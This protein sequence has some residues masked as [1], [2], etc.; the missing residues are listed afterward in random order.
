[1]GFRF[2]AERAAHELGIRGYV[3]NLSS[4]SVEVYAIGDENTLEAFQRL[5]AQGPRSAR[6]NGIQESEEPVRK[7]YDRFR[8]E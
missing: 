2:F 8:I 3:K 1:M 4:G 7:G 5:L 6:V